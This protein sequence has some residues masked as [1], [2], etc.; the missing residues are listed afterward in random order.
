M[1]RASLAILLVGAGVAA[2]GV[3]T[4]RS[5]L[6]PVPPAAIDVE[7]SKT[8]EVMTVEYLVKEPFP[9]LET[10]G[11]LVDTLKAEGW[12][13]LE[14]GTFARITPQKPALLAPTQRDTHV[15][16]GR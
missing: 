4:V 3:D 13:L 16:E 14:L 12:T 5:Q 1:E 11:Y 9:A 8:G 2:S 15:W 10:I 7:T 6:P